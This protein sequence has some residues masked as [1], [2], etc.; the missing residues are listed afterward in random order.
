MQST[1]AVPVGFQELSYFCCA[2]NGKGLCTSSEC[3]RGLDSIA[4]DGPKEEVWWKEFD[5]KHELLGKMK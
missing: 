5:A 4:C 2:A 1:P 3:H